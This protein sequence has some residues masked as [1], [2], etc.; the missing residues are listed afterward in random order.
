V[1]PAELQFAVPPGASGA[2]KVEL[3]SP[4]GTFVGNLQLTV[5]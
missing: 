2:C 1:T 4:A 5:S 3:V